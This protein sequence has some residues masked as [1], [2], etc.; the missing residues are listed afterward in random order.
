M[1]ILFHSLETIAMRGA[2]GLDTDARAAVVAALQTLQMADGG[3]TGLDGQSDPYYTLF[4]WLGLRALG[5]AYDRDQL[6]AY[7]TAYRCD[8]NPLDA[9]CAQ[10]CLSVE[11]GKIRLPHLRLVTELLR[12]D[13]YGAFLSAL[14]IG[15]LSR[16]LARLGMRRICSPDAVERLPT[17]RLAAGL[18]LAELADVEDEACR[19]VLESRHCPN[20]G[21]ASAPNAAADLLATAVARFALTRGE[22]DVAESAR[23]LAFIEACWLEG[24]LFGASPTAMRGDAE[25]T[26]YGLL[27]LGTCR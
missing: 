3:F 27:A 14:T 15:T 21:Y 16:W 8:A 5:G 13:A 11:S 24:G 18:V 26:F 25:H 9:R 10:F 4:A 23:D 12:G 2:T 1:P 19:C 22:E 7:M 17:P 20:G 6:C